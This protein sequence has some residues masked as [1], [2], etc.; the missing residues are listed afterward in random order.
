[1]GMNKN[2]DKDYEWRKKNIVRYELSL[3]VSTEK[4]VIRHLKRK[5]NKR[6]YI[7]ELI[8][9]DIKNGK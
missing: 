1:M 3:N 7:I 4:D 5:D 9:K 2:R 8:R 6:A